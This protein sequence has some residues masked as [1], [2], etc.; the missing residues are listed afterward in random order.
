VET[1][2]ESGSRKWVKATVAPGSAGVF[3]FTS[4]TAG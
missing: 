4:I 1:F 3:S 2:A